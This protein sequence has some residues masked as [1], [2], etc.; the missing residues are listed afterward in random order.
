MTLKRTL[1]AA[2]GLVAAAALLGVF[3]AG[4]ESTTATSF[5]PTAS[6]TLTDSAPGANSDI[7]GTYTIPAPDSNFQN[8]GVIAFTPPEWGIGSC[9]PNDPAA[10]NPGCADGA[11]TDGSR[12]AHLDSATTLGLF[13]GACATSISIPFELMDATTNMMNT[14]AFTDQNNDGTGDQFELQGGVPKGVI[15]YP[16]YLIA[17]MRTEPYPAGQPL[18]PIQRLFAQTPVA[19]T[20]VSLQYLVFAPG[21][22][23]NGRLLDSSQGFPTVSILQ[24]TGDPQADPLASNITD[25]CTTLDVD[26]TGFGLTRDNPSTAANEAG[27]VNRTNPA[28]GGYNFTTFSL[29]QPDADD[30]G[31]ENALDPC[32]LEGNAGG[33]DPRLPNG[34]ANADDDSDGIPNVCDMD[35]TTFFNNNVDGDVDGDG[36]GFPNR[37]DNC[38]QVA[39]NTQLDSDSDGIGDACDPD[40]NAVN[41]HQHESCYPDEV[42]VGAGGTPNNDPLNF[43]PCGPGVTTPTPS[44][45][46]TPATETPT[47]TPVTQTPTATPGTETPTGTPTDSPTPTPT[48]APNKFG[49]VNCDGVVNSLDALTILLSISN[50]PFN[51]PAGCPG[52]TNLTLADVNCDGVVD[53]LD[54]LVLLLFVSNLPYMQGSGCPPIDQ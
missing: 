54:A 18:Q 44:A 4:G 35:N 9:P 52:P 20:D 22:M 30:D 25:F 1:L 49:D 21:T 10:A 26:L 38:P 34:P 45:S 12:V 31:I 43:E 48:A 36:V 7:I 14:V 17:V 13:N 23:F 33:W 15:L 51:I 8:V 41:G 11:I 46:A 16:D 39:N 47:A 32:P 40:D 37:Q 2:F 27:Q 42:D 3:L 6:A 28:D 5:N 19:G 29:S 53:S 24:N 50:L